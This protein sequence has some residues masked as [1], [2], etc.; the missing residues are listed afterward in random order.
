MMKNE[1]L[2]MAALGITV[3]SFTRRKESFDYRTCVMCLLFRC[4]AT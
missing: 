1:L 2:A 3:A 4:V